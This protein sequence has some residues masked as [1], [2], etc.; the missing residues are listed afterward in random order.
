MGRG[1]SIKHCEKRLPLKWSTF[2]ERHNFPRIW[3][4]DLRFRIWGLEIKHLKAHN[5]V[6]QGCVYFHCYVATSMTDW[7][8]IF[9]GLLHICIC[10]DTASEKT[11][12]WQ[13]PIVSSAFIGSLCRYHI[14]CISRLCKLYQIYKCN[15]QW[16]TW[17]CLTHWNNTF[18]IRFSF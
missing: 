9:T 3:F 16:F 2:R 18:K 10:W 12:L 8:Q 4:R 5:F 15:F 17:S 14:Y 1:C 7:A 6:W 13:L 11:G